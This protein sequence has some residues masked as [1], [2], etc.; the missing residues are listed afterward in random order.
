MYARVTSYHVDPARL[1]EMD[2]ELADLE[3]QC[4][5]LPGIKSYYTA[6]RE[7]GRGISMTIYDCR[8]SCEEAGPA[9]NDIWSS[10]SKL[11]IANPVTE[12]YD[13]TKDMLA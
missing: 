1:G 7:D 11:L 6:W 4:M 12:L 9:L 10:F 3:Q 5:A 13:R 8:A 2:A